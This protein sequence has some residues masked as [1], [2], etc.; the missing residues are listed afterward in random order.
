ME[1]SDEMVFIEFFVRMY[2]YPTYQVFL[3]AVLS[4]L[5]TVILTPLWIKVLKKRNVGQ[6][7]REDGPEHHI[8]KQGTPTMGGL[9]IIVVVLLSF[10]LMGFVRVFRL[11]DG[12]ELKHLLLQ[13]SILA[14]GVMIACG[15][16]GLIDDY[17]AV[18]KE[19]SLGLRARYKIFAQLVVSLGL[20]WIAVEYLHL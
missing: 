4:V 1:R 6:V 11:P 5:L 12:F 8:E 19:R 20:G 9:L 14:L 13:P 7:I 17:L 3:T 15:M 16:I 2:R 10:A 18:L